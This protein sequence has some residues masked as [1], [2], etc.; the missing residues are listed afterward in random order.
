[1]ENS[2]KCSKCSWPL[3]ESSGSLYCW[4]PD[5]DYM[6]SSNTKK[7]TKHINKKKNVKKAFTSVKRRAFF[8][9]LVDLIYKVEF[10]WVAWFVFLS[11]ILIYEDRLSDSMDLFDWFYIFHL[12]WFIRFW[13]RIRGTTLDFILALVPMGLYGFDE[14]LNVIGLDRDIA[15]AVNVFFGW[16]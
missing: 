12:Y 9:K 10:I 5:C 15:F 8:L 3:E 6:T 11:S 16:A 7:E 2:Y 14:F 4:N 1:M 13:F